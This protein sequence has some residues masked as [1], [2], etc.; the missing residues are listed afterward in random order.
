MTLGEL[1]TDLYGRLG[2]QT[3]PAAEVVARLDRFVNEAYMEILTMRGLTQLRRSMLT[4]TC[5]ANNPLCS[6]PQAVVRIGGIQDRSTQ[7]SLSEVSTQ[8]IRFQ[9]PGLVRLMSNPDAYSIIN[10]SAATLRD[11]LTEALTAVSTAADISTLY[12]Q[13]VTDGGF[14]RTDAIQLNSMTPVTTAVTTWI[15]IQKL[16][17]DAPAIGIVTIAGATSLNAIS[18]ITPGLS[19]PRYT[20]IHLFGT[21]TQVNTYYADV[22]LH[23]EKLAGPADSSLIPEDFDW[24]LVC[25][26]L[27]KEYQKR[28][29]FNDYGIEQARYR[30]GVS[31]LKGWIRARSDDGHTRMPGQFSQLGP[32]FPAGS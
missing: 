28:Q 16:Y 29:Q 18:F 31:T 26:A 6:L 2:Y 30:D 11:P 27:K 20:R 4:F 25:G 22:D 13:G 3:T 23:I 1:R 24:L 15:Q 17:L 9:D 7:R 21:P 19:R 32:W 14:P 12:V 8:D 5:I 10:Y